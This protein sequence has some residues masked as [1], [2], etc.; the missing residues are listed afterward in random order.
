MS[1]DQK[2]KKDTSFRKEISPSERLCLTIHYHAYGNSQHD[3]SFTYRIGRSTVSVIIR[4]I[5]EA[6]WGNLSEQYCR[7]PQNK[8]H[9]N[10]IAKDIEEI[11]N[12]PLC[13][14]AIEIKH[15]AIKSP[16]NSG[17]LYFTYKGFFGIVL[18]G[19]CDACYVFTLVDIGSYGSNNDSGVIHNSTMG[20][21]FFKNRMSL[22]NPEVISKYCSRQELP[23]Y[24]VGDDTFPLQPWLLRPYPGKNISEEDAI[25]NYR[26]SRARLVIENSFGILAARWRIFLQTI[27]SNVETVNAIFRAAIC[28]HNFLF[29][30]NKHCSILS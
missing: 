23:Y 29:K 2:F 9:W 1:L 8:E 12:L 4:E 18:T 14:G 25:F 6:M 26:L 28:L 3:L 11:W 5:Y 19:I 7:P 15:I 21:E 16:I 10:Q 27:Q 24:L 20:K 30:T 22:P 17:S 13:V